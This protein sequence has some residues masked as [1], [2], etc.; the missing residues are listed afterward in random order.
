MLPRKKV[1]LLHCEYLQKAGEDAVVRNES[2]LLEQHYQLLRFIRS[3]EELRQLGRLAQLGK[4]IWNFEL[5][6]EL[7]QFLDQHCPDI[8][9]VHNTFPLFSP[10][11]FR[12]LGRWKRRRAKLGQRVK[13]VMTLHNFRLHCPQASLMRPLRTV[14]GRK[15]GSELCQRCFGQGKFAGF[16]P[17]L[18]ARCYRNSLTMTAAVAAMLLLHKILGSWHNNVDAFI[19]LNAAQKTLLGRVGFPVQKFVYKPNF[20]PCSPADSQVWAP[21]G[22]GMGDSL[23]LLF[24]GRLSVEKGLL[25]LLRAVQTLQ[26]EYTGSRSIRLCIAGDGPLR[27]ELEA[28]IAASPPAPAL[29]NGLIVEYLGS[30]SGAALQDQMQSCHFLLLPSIWYEGMPMTLLE[31]LAHGRPVIS[32]RL[33]ASA[34]MLCSDAEGENAILLPFFR[35]DLAERELLL[36]QSHGSAE[37]A[38][39]LAAAITQAATIAPE[40]YW[41]MCAA[42][43]RSFERHYTAQKNFGLLRSIYEGD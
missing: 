8:V 11:V 27:P 28:S 13:I 12:T 20:L 38:R 10:A 37:L 15:E 34:E 21:L 41:R 39:S 33:G 43:R 42:A 29:G 23:R 35:N 22:G 16:L 24:A 14:W 6:R 19:Y 7:W 4:S 5:C 17:A 36:K 31:I 3:N 32:F 25:I 2:A 1:L 40:R 18:R 30:L 9:H 26:Q